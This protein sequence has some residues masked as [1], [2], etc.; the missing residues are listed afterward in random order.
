[1]TNFE[2]IEEISKEIFKDSFVLVERVNNAS[3][4]H[5]YLSLNL[6]GEQI[7][8]LESK[9][10][11]LFVSHGY[12]EDEKRIGKKI[13][14]VIVVS[15]LDT[16]PAAQLLKELIKDIKEIPDGDVDRYLIIDE[17]EKIIKEIKV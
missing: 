5:I 10:K 14:N 9:F 13:L 12:P 16:K 6:Q 3:L 8:K 2:K 4:R 17:I 7:K 15:E 1:M 11:I